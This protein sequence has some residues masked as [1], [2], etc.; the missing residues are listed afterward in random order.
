[1]SNVSTMLAMLASTFG[2]DPDDYSDDTELVTA[3]AANQAALQAQVS[4]LSASLAQANAPKAT[5]WVSP[6]E[7]LL[8]PVTNTGNTNKTATAWVS[9]VSKWLQS[10]NPLADPMTSQAGYSMETLTQ[11]EF[12]LALYDTLG[13]LVGMG[14]PSVAER[15]AFD[16]GLA[17]RY[18]ELT[19]VSVDR[20]RS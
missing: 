20:L 13:E 15:D 19:L 5:R 6:L 18:D 10:T 9:R 16:A 3:I 1:M 2:I 17:R 7:S 14:L 8:D 12:R 11:K 4:S